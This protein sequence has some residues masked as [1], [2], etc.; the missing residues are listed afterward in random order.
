MDHKTRAGWATVLLAISWGVALTIGFVSSYDNFAL[1]YSYEL[2]DD[3]RAPIE[4]VLPTSQAGD[5]KRVI[6]VVVE[7]GRADALEISSLAGNISQAR[8]NGTR[9][10]EC[11]ARF[12]TSTK[13]AVGSIYTGAAPFTHP[14]L[15]ND[16]VLPAQMPCETIFRVTCRL[17][18][19]TM[20]YGDPKWKELFSPYV[21]DSYTDLSTFL[22]EYIY[23]LPL[24]AAVHL[25]ATDA[26]GWAHG[27]NSPEYAEA[28][29]TV[30]N[31]F[32]L[33]LQS[34]DE[35][36]LLS[37]TLIVLTTTSGHVNALQNGQG[38]NGGEESVV[39]NTFAFFAGSG[40]NRNGLCNM[41]AH[42][43][44]IAPTIAYLM[45]WPLPTHSNGQVLFSLLNSTAAGAN[46]YR[47]N[48]SIGIQ[49]AERALGL[50]NATGKVLQVEKS[51]DM[52][53]NF[54]RDLADLKYFVYFT[55]S[56]R[57]E[58]TAGK[59]RHD[60]EEVQE[61]WVEERIF[62]ERFTRFMGIVAVV[63]LIF[64]IALRLVKRNRFVIE[65]GQ[66][67]LGFINTGLLNGLIWVMYWIFGEFFTFSTFYALFEPLQYPILLGLGVLF[68]GGPLILSL[69]RVA[70]IKRNG[71]APENDF[72]STLGIHVMCNYLLVLWTFVVYGYKITYVFPEAWVI[73][74][75]YVP[76]IYALVMLIFGPVFFGIK[77]AYDRLLR[78]WVKPKFEHVID[79]REYWHI[80]SRDEQAILEY[81]RRI[82]ATAAAV[83]EMEAKTNNNGADLPNSPPPAEK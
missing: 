74:P 53:A 69:T 9:L 71:Y 40:V 48:A 3:T 79:S 34:L 43:E 39:A 23:H 15:T 77:R 54:T 24:F 6:L 78:R 16:Q 57:I 82:V 36:K 28:V 18:G 22:D 59:L 80:I 20:L 52:I 56:R 37:E 44:D 61:I 30:D 7:G 4:P 60:I 42:L 8:L 63:F 32:G 38:G 47:R 81:R 10:G 31:Q 70:F 13:P 41:P 2:H 29:R 62:K 11:S 64:F 58:A 65:K 19:R 68:V 17:G 73:M 14:Y 46:P 72:T 27:G 21:N 12:P 33:L 45:G 26:A 55:D 76:V 66:L 83:R 75:G 25:N 49:L 67:A 5:M 50:L 51:P 1:N 35:K